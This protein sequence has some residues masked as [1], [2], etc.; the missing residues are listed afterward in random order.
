MPRAKRAVA[1]YL[2]PLKPSVRAILPKVLRFLR[3]SGVEPLGLDTQVADFPSEVRC[4]PAAQLARRALFALVMG[5][6]GTFLSAARAFCRTGLPLAGMRLGHTGFLTLIES[7]GFQ[8]PLREALAGKCIIESRSMVEARVVG[9]GGRIVARGTALNDITLKQADMVKVVRLKLALDGE[10]LG[11][12]TADGLV[13]ATPTGATAYSLSAGGPVVIPG[14][15]ILLATLLCP[16]TLSSRPIAFSPR[17]T[18]EIRV[19]QGA[20][21]LRVSLDGQQTLPMSG[22]D[23]IAVTGSRLA[24]R[25]L[26]PPGF[27]YPELLRTKLGWKS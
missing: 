24:T 21:G 8:G 19:A 14:A 16:H 1:L 4:L 5:G 25:V 6:D 15:S 7:H 2:N 12:F 23:R 13:V 3:D 10:R 18:L 27:S 22:T 9:A 20:R 17:Q 11:D 26:R